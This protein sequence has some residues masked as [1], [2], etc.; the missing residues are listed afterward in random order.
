MS[1]Q[2]NLPANPS[3]FPESVEYFDGI[4]NRSVIAGGMTLRDYFAIHI[5]NGYIC[6]SEGSYGLE[7]E[8]LVKSAFGLADH[9]LKE[10]EKPRKEGAK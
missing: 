4:E 10:R 7:E 5:L 9:M 1:D 2:E 3:A 6:D 8:D